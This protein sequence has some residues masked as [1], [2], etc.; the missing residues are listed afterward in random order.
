VA[1]IFTSLHFDGTVTTREH[2]FDLCGF[3][4]MWLRM[5]KYVGG[6]KKYGML[7]NL[8]KHG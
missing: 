7:K 6:K 3:Y 8:D 2:G 1:Y 5:V 4:Y